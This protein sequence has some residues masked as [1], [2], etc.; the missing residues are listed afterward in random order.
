MSAGGWMAA[1]VK[2]PGAL[3]ATAKREGLIRGD[4][5][6]SHRVLAKLANSKDPKTR[7]RATLAETFAKE[8][9]H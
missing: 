8:R 1:A 5:T 7:R 2:H 6:L 3:R 9:S 4:Q